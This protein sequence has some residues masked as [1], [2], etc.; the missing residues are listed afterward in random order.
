M[1]ND[2]YTDFVSSLYSNLNTE[3]WDSLDFAPSD[4]PNVSGFFDVYNNLAG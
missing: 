4:E 2:I 3:L 1:F